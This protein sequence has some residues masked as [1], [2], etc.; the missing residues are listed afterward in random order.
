MNN[1]LSLDAMIGIAF[2]IFAF[3]LT[4]FSPKVAL[5]VVCCGIVYL[6]WRWLATIAPVTAQVLLAIFMF[7]LYVLVLL[8][9]G[10]R[11]GGYYRGRRWW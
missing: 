10:G 3:S 2:A 7:F 9:T 5:F 11:G 4:G 6:L 8:I 1:K